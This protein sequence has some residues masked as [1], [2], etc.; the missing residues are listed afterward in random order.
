MTRADALRECAGFRDSRRSRL[1]SYR[2]SDS[3]A[4]SSTRARLRPP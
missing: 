4:S 3:K 2:V 1:T